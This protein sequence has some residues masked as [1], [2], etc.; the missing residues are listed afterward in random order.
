MRDKLRLGYW[1]P[2]G[3]IL[4]IVAAVWLPLPRYAQGLEAREFVVWL[5]RLA[6]VVGVPLAFGLILWAVWRWRWRGRRAGRGAA[7]PAASDPEA[8]L[9]AA[10]EAAEGNLQSPENQARH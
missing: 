6:W 4:V 3:L 10:S 9:G 8:G 2:R 1:L 5:A 7:S